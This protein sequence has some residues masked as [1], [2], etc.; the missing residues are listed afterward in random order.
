EDPHDDWPVFGHWPVPFDLPVIP[1][2][3]LER[4]WPAGRLVPPYPKEYEAWILP[5]NGRQVILWGK[6]LPPGEEFHL[7][8]AQGK[9]PLL[10][11]HWIGLVSTEKRGIAPEEADLVIRERTRQPSPEERRVLTCC[12]FDEPVPKTIQPWDSVLLAGTLQ[13]VPGWP[14]YLFHCR[15]VH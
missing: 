15:L 8:R 2:E 13:L 11:T 3:E 7:P 1:C 14:P 4:G 10:R 6:V 12:L 9:T 5:Y